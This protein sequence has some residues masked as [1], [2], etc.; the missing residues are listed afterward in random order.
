MTGLNAADEAFRAKLAAQI[1]ENCFRP[2]SP[3]YLEDPR[4][5]LH[6]IA[7]LIVAPRNVEEVA[8]IVRSCAANKVPIVPFGGGTGL[9]GGQIMTD[10][11]APVVLSME[12]MKSIRQ[13]LPLENVIVVEAG[14]TLMA[15]QEAA[16]D[17]GLLFPLSLAAEGSCQIGGNLATNAGGVNVLRYGNMRDLCTGIEAVLPDGQIWNGLTRLKKDNTGFDLR[18]LLIGSEGALG[19]IT[20]ASLK[21]Y[22]RPSE[23][24][25]SLMAVDSPDAAL[26]LLAQ[27]RNIAGE[28]ISAFE[29][30]QR[31]GF[32]FLTETMP[33]VRLP[34]ETSPEWTVLIELGLQNGQ[35]GEAMLMSIFEYGLEE[36][37]VHDGLIAQSVGQRA[38]FW[39]AREHIPDANRMIGAIASHDVSLPLSGLP[40]FIELASADITQLAR[41]RINCFGHLGDGNLHFNVF[42]PTGETRDNYMGLK[43]AIEEIVHDLVHQLGGSISAEHGIGRTKVQALEKYGDPAKL[44]ALKAIKSALDPLAIMNPGAVLAT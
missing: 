17:A 2:L 4:G 30:I 39:N 11:P 23:Y 24:F 31:T 41:L 21:L 13:M 26:T 29:I 27:T 37:L 44:S 20:A 25:C 36:G 12:R 22:P 28:A 38:E 7:G 43:S 34:F 5:N 32:D 16:D 6:G 40:K 9:V 15:V 33:D 1:D 42:P 10:G 35:D 19:I 18:N 8:A 3:T 14:A